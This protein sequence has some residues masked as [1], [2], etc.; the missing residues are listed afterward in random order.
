MVA[1]ESGFSLNENK[2]QN[3]GGVGAVV[4]GESERPAR[5]SPR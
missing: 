5:P 2:I 4:G 3:N 1:V